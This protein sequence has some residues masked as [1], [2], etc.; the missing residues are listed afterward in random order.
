MR[1]VGEIGWRMAEIAG[2]QE[3]RVGGQS[4]WRDPKVTEGCGLVGRGAWE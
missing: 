2:M 4:V 1:D 3:D